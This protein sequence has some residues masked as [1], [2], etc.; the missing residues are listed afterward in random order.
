MPKSRTGAAARARRR[1]A[2]GAW[3]GWHAGSTDPDCTLL[4]R[5]PGRVCRVLFLRRCAW[6]HRRTHS[7]SRRG[8]L[9]LRLHRQAYRERDDEC[10]SYYQSGTYPHGGPP[11]APICLLRVPASRL[12]ENAAAKLGFPRASRSETCHMSATRALARTEEVATPP[13][14]GHPDP[15]APAAS[16]D[17]GAPIRATREQEFL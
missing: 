4:Y 14:I 15:G 17:R 3:L 11:F 10:A 13:A 16:V 7:R 5:G 1:A 6:H 8:S 12:G 2:F 9:L